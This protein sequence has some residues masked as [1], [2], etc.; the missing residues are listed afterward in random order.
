MNSTAECRHSH[1]KFTNCP[2]DDAPNGG[3]TF[4]G[5]HFVNPEKRQAGWQF[6]SE[7]GSQFE[8]ASES[9]R[10]SRNTLLDLAQDLALAR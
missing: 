8:R 1:S 2:I 7:T 5:S 4:N 3:R 10:V 9:K 6:S